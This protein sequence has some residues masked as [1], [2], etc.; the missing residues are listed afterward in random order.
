MLYPEVR[1]RCFEL[2]TILNVGG[3]TNGAIFCFETALIWMESNSF[4]SVSFFFAAPIT[5]A[6]EKG[7][8]TDL[9]LLVYNTWLAN[10]FAKDRPT[11]DFQR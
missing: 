3:N 7:K 11:S 4:L 5:L 10:N 6:I 9:S 1:Y 8:I 2:A